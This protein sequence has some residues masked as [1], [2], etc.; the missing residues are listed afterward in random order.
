MAQP[1]IL[2]V[3]TP[4][5]PTNYTS[6]SGAQLQQFGSGIIPYTDKG[7]VVV[8]TDIGGV[9]QVPNANT[10]PKW[11]NYIWV[12]Q[13]VSSVSIYAWAVGAASDATFLQWI[14]SNQ[15]GI[16]AGSITGAQIAF[17]TITPNN[18]A[19]V[20]WSQ[21]VGAPSALTPSGPAGG[22]LTGTYPNPSILAGAVTGAMIAAT[23]ITGANVAANTIGVGNIAA[24]GTALALLRTNAGATASEWAASS[25]IAF[26]AGGVTTS[27]AQFKIPQVATSGAGDTGTW[28]MVTP[29]QLLGQA[30]VRF[31]SAAVALSAGAQL[32]NSA[33]GLASLPANLRCVA[34]CGTG[35]A[36]YSVGDEVDVESFEVSGGTGP[37]FGYGANA[38][39][40][41]VA[42]GSAATPGNLNVFHKTTGVLTAITAGDWTIKMYASI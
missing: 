15:S 36:G 12:R 25:S 17:N 8:T 39:N 27:A 20:N 37:G 31:T 2:D 16:A 22:V 24:S 13:S 9:P 35:N 23:T 41:F 5:D 6:I 34:V 19:A 42:Q 3:L 11:Q 29:A 10:N 1:S 4:F 32:I 28:Q 14:P 7:L 26:A 33:H 40:V 18:I 38:T 21:I 30:S